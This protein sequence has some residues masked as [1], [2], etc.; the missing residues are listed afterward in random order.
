M[1]EMLRRSGF[2]RPTFP[3]PVSN[4]FE[5]Q[6]LRAAV[7]QTFIAE[8]VTKRIFRET[9]RLPRWTG[10]PLI[11][12]KLQHFAERYPLREAAFRSIMVTAYSAEE[13]ESDEREINKILDELCYTFKPLLTE[14]DSFKGQLRDLL[15]EATHIW[16]RARA[17]IDRISATTNPSLFNTEFERYDLDE[18]CSFRN[19][20]KD[21]LCDALVLFPRIFISNQKKSEVLHHGTVLMSDSALVNAA[22]I[23][24]KEQM[25]RFYAMRRP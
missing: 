7:A 23:E 16:S 10:L 14:N 18:A 12:E 20:D 5:S 17:N 15:N 11:H 21:A 19:D 25:N 3:I 22:Q 13:N 4:S 6:K 1:F 8:Q 9:P 24:A 2:L